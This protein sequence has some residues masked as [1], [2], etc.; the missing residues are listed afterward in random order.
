MS[1]AAALL[2]PMLAL[3]DRIRDSVVDACTKQRIDQ[4]AAV[5]AEEASDTIYEVDRVSEEILVAGLETVARDE[6]LCLMAEGLA[7]G[8]MVLP[9]DARESDCRW[10]V[11][12]DPI[13]GTR[14]IMYQKR[15]AWILTGVAPNQGAGTRLRDITL[16]VQTEIP[17]VKQ[18]LSDQLW[19]LRGQGAHATRFNRITGTSEL[20]TVRPSTAETIAHGF[21]TVSRFFP[22][23]R[24]VLSAIEDEMVH[25][26]LGPPLAG[27]AACF[28]D[29]YLSTGGQLY[30]LMAGHDRF[31]ADVRPLMQPLYA[32]RGLPRGL[33]AHPYDICTALI[34][35]ELGVVV[36]DADGSP[37]DGPFDVESD[38]SWIGY[39]NERIRALVEPALQRALRRRGLL[40]VRDS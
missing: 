38:S 23:V 13:D 34:A 28:E 30:E 9:R 18:H 31:I 3:H 16:A 37:L 22:G 25:E 17:L 1:E 4:L 39:A 11:I 26:V 12:V 7:G 5:S 6:P 27:K 36:T 29:Q 21:S 8:T 19:A 40:P 15:S 35:E 14:G 10:R 24:D 32:E 2:E 33:C 20:L